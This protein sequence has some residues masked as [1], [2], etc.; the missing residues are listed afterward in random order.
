MGAEGL[1]VEGL[2]GR[3]GSGDDADHI[4][5]RAPD[6]KIDDHPAEVGQASRVEHAH[7]DHRADDGADP[8]EVSQ[9]HQPADAQFLLRSDLHV[10]EEDD[11]KGC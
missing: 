1:D 5:D 9:A 8:A 6:A 2:Q 10:P 7:R 4:L 11:R 3:D